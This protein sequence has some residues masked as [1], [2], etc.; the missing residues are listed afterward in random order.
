MA[1][2]LSDEQRELQRGTRDFLAA[3]LPID[4]VG[5][6]ANGQ[7]DADLW[8]E[9][10]ELGIFHLCL[11][12]SKGGL[13]LS[14]VDAAVVFE[15]LGRALVPGPLI[16]THLAAPWIPGAGDG[17]RVVAGLDTT[18]NLHTVTMLEHLH[19][20]DEVLVL[21]REGVRRI[22][23]PAIQGSAVEPPLDPLTPVYRVENLPDGERIAGPQSA[24]ELGRRGAL[25]SAAMMLGIAEATCERGVAYAKEREQFGRPIGA[26][27]AIKH[28]LADCFVR[29]E[30]ARAAV[31]AAAGTCDH[32][33]VGDPS[34]AVSQAKIL[35]GEAAMKNS[36]SSIQVHGGM[37]YTWEVPAH[38]FLKRTW[39]LE[40]S[41]GS[42]EE[43]TD[44][45][46]D[47]FAA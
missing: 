35:A 19:G 2:T 38:L 33:E 43:H 28:M 27:Q 40:T 31:Y 9:L 13:G 41:F 7:A 32:P 16:W 6:M 42:V 15:E 44:R 26:F 5:E 37:G 45:L 24:I 17:S 8:S 1:F 10:A 30:L 18:T 4:K 34:E 23:A 36:R 20:A 46:A 11:E 47:N 39:V 21:D 12:E 25:L 29:Q 3:R 22:E 14:H